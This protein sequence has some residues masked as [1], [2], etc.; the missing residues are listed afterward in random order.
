[1]AVL[2]SVLVGA[3]IVGGI[4]WARDDGNNGTSATTN[5]AAS[6]PA[7]AQS[8][9]TSAS[10][11]KNA[12]SAQVQEG[13]Y[14]S[15]Y[16]NVRPSIVRITT[17]T[18]SGNPFSP[19]AEGLGSGIVLDTEGHILTNYHVVS[20]STTVTVTFADETTAEADVVGKDPG[21]DVAVIKV[22]GVDASELHPATLGDSSEVID[23]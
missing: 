2:L 3:A 18:G 13:D 5:T 1:M 23:A 17:G 20:G 14:T 22:S 8:S 21:N 4:V 7:A 6:S 12:S 10:T 16:D 15:L 9:S 11:T 19:Q